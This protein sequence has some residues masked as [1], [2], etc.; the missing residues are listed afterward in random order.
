M[1]RVSTLQ[2]REAITPIKIRLVEAMTQ[3]VFSTGEMCPEVEASK[4][5]YRFEIINRGN[6]VPI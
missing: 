6:T 1:A 4:Y 2:A 5:V 3:T